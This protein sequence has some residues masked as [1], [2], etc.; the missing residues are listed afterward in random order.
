MQFT[1]R[2]IAQ[3]LDGEVEG[4]AHVVITG[5]GKIES[6]TQNDLAFLSNP[7][8]EQFIYETNAGAVL[9]DRTFKPKQNLRSVLIRVKDA[10][11]GFTSLLDHFQQLTSSHK[12]GVEQ[13]SYIGT[14]TTLP[15]GVYI[16][17]FAYIGNNVKI[18]KNVKIYPHAWI[19][20]DVEI[21]EGTSIY[22]GAKVYRKTKIGKNCTLHA[23]CVIGADGFGFAPKED[24]TYETIPQLGIV[25][26]EDEV[27]IGAST[28]VDRATMGETRVGQ[29]TK[30]DNLVM[31]GHNVELG[32]NIVMAAQ[33]GIS[34]SSKVGDNSMIA[35]QVGIAGHV[36]IPE[37]SI[38]MAQSGIS[39]DLPAPGKKWLGS[40]AKELGDEA[41]S[42]AVYKNL[43]Q[44]KKAVDELLKW[45]KESADK[46][47]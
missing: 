33:S 44:L 38:I 41:K 28:T 20:D 32:K 35:G 43:P 23:N 15:E 36:V 19:D 6:A 26:L 27:S 46:K 30:L 25:I 29:G 17:A 47:E 2:E 8:Y 40:P 10:Y 34:G 4:E 45:K 7:K 12:N 14:G 18:E 13:P 9:V 24:G 31:L 11:L 37:K 3:M 39:K 42:M 16:G 22:S 5:V 1:V 21:G